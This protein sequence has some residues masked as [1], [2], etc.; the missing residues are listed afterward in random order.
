MFGPGLLGTLGGYIC[1]SNR[2]AVNEIFF[3]R[4]AASQAKENVEPSV[5]NRAFARYE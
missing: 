2:K 4:G 1:F 3:S 5:L